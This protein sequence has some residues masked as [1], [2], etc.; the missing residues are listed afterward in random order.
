VVNTALSYIAR[1]KDNAWYKD[2]LSTWAKKNEKK[3]ER[4]Y[5]RHEIEHLMDTVWVDAKETVNRYI[6]K[7]K[8][9]PVWNF[10]KKLLEVEK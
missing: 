5:S 6:E 10:K 2:Q 4:T 9:W 3:I 1:P 8:S 7:V